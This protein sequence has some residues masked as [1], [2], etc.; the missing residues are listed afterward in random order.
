M[1][2]NCAQLRQS[3]AHLQ[4]QL[5]VLTNKQNEETPKPEPKPEKQEKKK[6]KSKKNKHE[7]K[8]EN[9]APKE[10]RVLTNENQT[11]TS[12]KLSQNTDKA[13]ETTLETLIQAINNANIN[14]CDL[15]VVSDEIAETVKSNFEIKE[16]T[17]EE[18]AELKLK[19]KE[20][21]PNVEEIVLNAEVG[22]KIDEDALNDGDK[23]KDD[24]VILNELV[25][26]KVDK[27][28]L[29]EAVSSKVEEITPNVEVSPEVAIN[30]VKNALTN[31]NLNSP[32]SP[33][34]SKVIQNGD[35]NLSGH[36]ET[37]KEVN[38][39]ADDANVS[40]VES[41]NDEVSHINEVK[42][43]LNNA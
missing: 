20:V 29:N 14:L 11:N 32:S 23:S 6:S 10:E 4:T 34:E 15:E 8:S 17:D 27:V 22:S 9:I 43:I 1:A 42:P 37:K 28:N 38:L 41:V 30:E 7:K 26:S 31:L 12:E 25:D 18:I 35:S 3:L 24:T 36:V 2:A 16:I 5:N 19:T 39:E 40:V 21:N 33:G 13:D